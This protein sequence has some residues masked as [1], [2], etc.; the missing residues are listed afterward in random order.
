MSV[1]KASRYSN[2]RYTSVKF[3][4]GSVKIYLHSRKLVAKDDI[5]TPLSVVDIASFNE[6]DEVAHKLGGDESKW[7][8][9]ADLNDIMFPLDLANIDE[10]LVPEKEEFNRL[11][12]GR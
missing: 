2:V 4:D 12:R 3:L 9:I 1:Y 7:W 5:Q 11:S 8:L 10:L 6:V